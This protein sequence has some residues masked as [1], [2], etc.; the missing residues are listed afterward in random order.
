MKHLPVEVGLSTPIVTYS[1]AHPAFCTMGNRSLFPG[2]KYLG[3]GIDH[4]PPSS[5]DIK[6]RVE[7]YLHSVFGPSWPV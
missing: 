2:V 7:L 5:V 1:E 3:H 6:E 4:L